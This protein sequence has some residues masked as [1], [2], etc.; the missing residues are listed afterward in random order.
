[1]SIFNDSY[2]LKLMYVPAE[3]KSVRIEARVDRV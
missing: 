1:M 3:D 2:K